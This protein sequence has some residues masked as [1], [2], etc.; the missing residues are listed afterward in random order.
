[1]TALFIN[2]FVGLYCPFRTARIVP[3][4]RQWNIF[5]V[6][7]SLIKLLG[8]WIMTI[9]ET[10]KKMNLAIIQSSLD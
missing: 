8:G 6:K 2:T 9:I 5:D 7:A 1:M 3:V 4:L 10:Q